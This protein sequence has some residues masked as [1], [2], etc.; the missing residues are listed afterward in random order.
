VRQHSL[1]ASVLAWV[2]AVSAW[3]KDPKAAKAKCEMPQ[4][5]GPEVTLPVIV[6]ASDP[7]IP[8]FARNLGPRSDLVVLEV[9]VGSNGKPCDIQIEKSSDPRFEPAARQTVRNWRWKP[10]K[11]NG[12]TVAMLTTVGVSFRVLN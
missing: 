11:K 7:E 6:S 8:A 2:L 1:I 12:K 9:L 3:G 10:A 4:A 5:A